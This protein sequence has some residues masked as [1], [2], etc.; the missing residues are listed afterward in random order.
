M[1]KDFGLEAIKKI[2]EIVPTSFL[3]FGTLLGCVRN[4]SF[5]S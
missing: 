4:N 1:R 2:Q 3:L 5:I